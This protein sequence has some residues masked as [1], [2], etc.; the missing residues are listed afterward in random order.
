LAIDKNPSSYPGKNWKKQRTNPMKEL[1]KKL[2]FGL[3]MPENRLNVNGIRQKCQGIVTK[4]RPVEGIKGF[5]RTAGTFRLNLKKRNSY[6]KI[7]FRFEE[8]DRC[9]FVFISCGP[10]NIGVV[11]IR[12]DNYIA[13][14]ECHLWYS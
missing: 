1:G 10:W 3:R 9:G 6:Q 4:G 13:E 7:P 12:L 14:F 11:L 2:T 5:V 8:T